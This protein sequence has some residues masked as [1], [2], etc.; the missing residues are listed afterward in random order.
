MI[1][2]VYFNTYK[3]DSRY[4]LKRK[5]WVSYRIDVVVGGKRYRNRFPKKSDAEEFI[6]QIREDAKLQKAGIRKRTNT[7]IRISQ[8]F[9]TYHNTI[10]NRAGKI[11]ATRVF[12]I[13][14][15][16]LG[17]DALVTDISRSHFNEY[18]R[19]RSDVKTT[20]INRELTVVISALKAAPDLF[21][22]ELAGYEPSTKRPP[23]P[24]SKPFK[25][26]ITEAEK[27]LIV[28]AIKNGRLK[29]EHPERSFS[30][31]GFADMFEVAW[32]LG[33]R[34]AEVRHLKRSDY[35]DLTGILTVKRP[36]T[37]TI[38]EM[39]FLPDRVLEIIRKKKSDE[40][41]FDIK[42]SQH[43]LEAIFRDACLAS[44]LKYGRQHGLTFHSTRHSF[45]TRLVGVT[46][47]ATAASYTG[48]SDK[49]MV[50]YYSHATEESQK[51]AMEA[52]YGGIDLKE[53]YEKVRS[54]T[55]SFDEFRA[56]LGRSK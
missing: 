22:D 49:E 18:I 41:L 24:K 20:T 16:V 14:K 25:K 51:A 36:K 40:P 2:P 35:S 28:S 50:A 56:R 12:R 53:I 29:R 31:K 5:K 26:V 42:C 38:T 9:E 17:H 1:V 44:G 15:D 47:I 11:R 7:R 39:K 13:F 8:L 32:M 55:M 19:F 30:R 46:D 23:R 34:F 48:H 6:S 27:D 43:T 52:L 45:T 3:K 4:D 37:G 21:P 10:K 33:L 54:G